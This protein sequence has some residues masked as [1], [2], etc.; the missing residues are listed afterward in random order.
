MLCG[1]HEI[2]SARQVANR[3][4]FMDAGTIVEIDEAGAFFSVPW[5]DRARDFL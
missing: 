1:T 4:G 2:G 3:V 5:P